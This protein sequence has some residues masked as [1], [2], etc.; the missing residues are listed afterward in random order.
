MLKTKFG[1]R[2]ERR[3]RLYTLKGAT[4]ERVWI[5]KQ[6]SNLFAAALN[7]ETGLLD[8]RPVTLRA[9]ESKHGSG[10]SPW[11][12]PPAPAPLPRPCTS[13]PYYL[14]PTRPRSLCSLGSCV[15]LSEASSLSPGCL[16]GAQGRAAVQRYPPL[17]CGPAAIS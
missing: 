3:S 14:W 4:E 11:R 13:N 15:V 10:C 12:N 5:Q 1:L 17:R 8:R 7:P 6:R 16:P 2:N 9:V